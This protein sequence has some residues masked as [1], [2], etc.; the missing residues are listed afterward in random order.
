MES[1]DAICVNPLCEKPITLTFRLCS[2]CEKI[3]G[4][5]REAWPEWLLYLAREKDREWNQ[6]YLAQEMGIEFVSWEE[7]DA[8]TLD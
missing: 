8:D 5:A 1:P 7:I 6:Y 4:S 2:E 3:Y